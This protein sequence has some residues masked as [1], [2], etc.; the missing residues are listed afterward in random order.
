M[1]PS[2]ESIEAFLGA[3]A[4][5]LPGPRRAR[6]EILA[7]LNDGLLEAADANQR[8]GL[9]HAQAVELA[10]REFGDPQMVARSFRPELML[11]Q[12]RRTAFALL[13][14]A[15]IVVGLWLAAARSRDT[16]GIS[17]MFDSP[18]DHIAAAVLI[19][20]VIAC[21]VWTIATTGRA[22]RW[23]GVP[24]HASLVGATAMGLITVLADVAA[25]AVLG[26][27]LAAFPGTIHALLLAAAIAAS[28]AS[29]LLAA[30]ATR[31]CMAMG[32][33]GRASGRDR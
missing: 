10:L 4:V 27:R 16:R 25:L 3:I 12:G 31:S 28:C 20:A 22:T 1:K 29:I 30:R 26:A 2:D 13:A 9:E 21:G 17:R 5:R 7:E 32:S 6:T 11:A 18:A 19:T 14:A 24:P 23:L 33:A 8:A 15:P